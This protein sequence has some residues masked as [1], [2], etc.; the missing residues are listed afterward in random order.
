MNGNRE[1][2][3]VGATRATASVVLILVGAVLLLAGTIALYARERVIDTDAFA[4]NAV[5]ALDD[6]GVRTLVGRELVVNVIDR[7]STDLVAARPLLESVVQAVMQTQ[8]FR[9]VF[10]EAAIQTNRIFFVRGRENALFDLGDASEVVRFAAR[11]VSPKVANEIPKDLQPDLLTLR[12]D[13]VAGR[14]LAIADDVRLL[15]VVLPLLA[16]LAFVGAIVVSP[17][18][19]VGVLRAG[20]AI[21]SVGVLIALAFVILRAR[22]LA[23]AIGEDELTD[24]DMRN[25]VGGVLDAF[26]GDLLGWG[27]LLALGGLV[28]AG[29]AAALDP[30]DLEA[31]SARLR[32][33][34]VE[35]PSTTPGRVLRGAAA[36]ALGVFVV[37]NPTL[38]LQLAA[39]VGGAYLVFFGTGELLALLQ[40]QG[41]SHAAAERTRRRAFATAGVAGAACVAALVAGILLVTSGDEDQ[42]T[43]RAAAARA[44]TC[45][46]SFALCELRLNE[47]VFAGTHNSFSAADSRGWFISN[48]RKG[49][50]DQLR[51][52]I[53]LFLIDPH[54]G[55]STGSGSVRT[56]FKSEGRSRNRVA[57][58]LPPETLRA[59]ERLAGRVGIGDSGGEREVWLCHTVCEL[60]ATRMVDSLREIRTFLDDN[61]GEVVILFIEP[62]VP[63]REIEKTFQETGLDRYVVTLARDE[64]LPT[65]G[66]LVRTNRRV[67]VFTEKD[68]DGTVP[69]YLDGFSFVQDTPLGAEKRDQLSCRRFRGT[70]DS[71][72]LMLNHWAD[73]FPP[74]LSA[75]PPFQRKRFILRRAHQCARARGL[76]VNLIAVDFYDQGDLIPAVETLNGERIRAVRRE[77]A[78]AQGG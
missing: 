40:R 48:Q 41:V 30:S 19:R 22:V 71:P 47:A 17:D 66:R 25:A 23:G 21:G 11:S 27:L 53:R 6:D 73:V 75:N 74:R 61:R 60:G 69:W 9:R 57:K 56:D 3:A 76:P 2:T 70:A 33:H 68:A 63:P 44:G 42:P 54:W 46:G 67:V 10:R 51:D 39:I 37:L 24:E 38:A 62:Y 18:R 45:N 26:V 77:R 43:A 4:D 59:A 36:F 49:I 50:P 7:G 65:L 8:P 31:P 29:A 55:V 15:G 52:G 5:A 13:E 64:P 28:V 16:L 34:L 35:R 12:R 72:M 14:T 20:V 58:A 1:A 78:A 32:R